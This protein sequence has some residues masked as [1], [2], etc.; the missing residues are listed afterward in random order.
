MLN[1]L[2]KALLEKVA[3]L[4]EIPIGAYSIRK[5]GEGIQKNSTA[6][7][8]VDAKTDKP[9]INVTVKPNTVNE[10]VHIPA[11]VTEEDT[12]DKVYN[13]IIVGEN[14]DVLVVAGCGIHNTGGKVASHDGVHDFYVKKGAKMRYVEKH[15]GQGPGAG[16]KILNPQTEIWAEEDSLVELELVQI[17]GV[18]DTKRNTTVHLGDRAKLIITERLLTTDAQKAI[19]S[20]NIKLEGEDST[21]QVISRSVARDQSVQDFFFDLSGENKCRGHIQCDAIIMDQATVLST[22]KVSAYH[23]EAQL[24]HE[25][26]IGRLESEQ[27]IKL[28]SIGLTEEEAESTILNGFLK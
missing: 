16:Q 6:N 13:T 10:S 18:D 25:A 12:E 2:D 3:D 4:H 8:T 20:V 22:P 15:Y 28:M 26:A 1:A 23:N 11:L 19:S 27:L 5:N 14:S 24:V 7:I 21:A 9:G 17:E